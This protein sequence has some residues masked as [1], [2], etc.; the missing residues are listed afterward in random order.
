MDMDCDS[1]LVT[2]GISNLGHPSFKKF[3]LIKLLDY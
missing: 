3:T 1:D 2:V